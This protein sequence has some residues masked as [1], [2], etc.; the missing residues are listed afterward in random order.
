MPDPARQ[1]KGKRRVVISP[2]QYQ[3]RPTEA[4]IASFAERGYVKLKGFLSAAEVARLRGAMDDAIA[5]LSSS[6]NGYDVTAAAD[7]FWT[8]QAAND[9]QGSDQHDLVALAQAVRSSTMPRL[10]DAAVAGR[11]RGKFLLDT[12]VWRRIPVLAR[13]ALASALPRGASDLLGCSTIRYYDDQMFVKEPGAVDRAAFH[14]D[15][16]YFNLDGEAGC[17][18]WIPL[19][20]VVEGGGRMGYV[21]GSHRW[22]SIYKPNIFVSALPFPGSEGADMPR[23]D[24]DP[25]AYGV[26]YI[27]VEPGDVIVHHFRTIHGSEGN[28]G[29]ASRRAFSLRY[30]DAALRFRL[31]PGAPLQPLHKQGMADGDPLDDAMHPVAWPSNDDARHER[32]TA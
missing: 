17:V 23:I 27:D 22:D 9:D 8:P 12:S 7:A 10:V 5:S 4:E 31:R 18:F 30:C 19:D 11:P 14:Q 29:S 2:Y 3:K 32:H 15:I 25:A 1:P 13:F 24:T 16:S 28:R 20:R 26:N 21:P 6:P